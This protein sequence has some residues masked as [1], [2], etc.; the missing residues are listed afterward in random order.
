MNPYPEQ[1]VHQSAVDLQ[2]TSK[3]HGSAACDEVSMFCL[4]AA[5]SDAVPCHAAFLASRYT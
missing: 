3:R 5:I 4:K 2:T 1:Q